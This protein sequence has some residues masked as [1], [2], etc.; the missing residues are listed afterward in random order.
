MSRQTVNLSRMLVA[1]CCLIVVAGAADA[2]IPGVRVMSDVAYGDNSRQRMDV[3]VP[4]QRPTD[5]P[6]IVMVH[7]GA[8]AIGDKDM[9]RVYENKVRRWV[10]KGF[11]FVSVNNRLVP[12]A[13]PIEQADDV[14]RALAVVQRQAS[15]WG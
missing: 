1:I 15:A 6:I 11:I 7:G 14:A 4:A 10:P 9:K 2:S 13:N 8:W 12:E 3:Y 5:A